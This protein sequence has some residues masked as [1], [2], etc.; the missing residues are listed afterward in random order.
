MQQF[1]EAIAKPLSTKQ[2]SMLSPKRCKKKNVETVHVLFLF[3]P[4]CDPKPCSGFT[5]I[6]VGVVVHDQPWNQPA[7]ELWIEP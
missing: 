7:W 4:V 2:K 6:V 1:D 5:R 3:I